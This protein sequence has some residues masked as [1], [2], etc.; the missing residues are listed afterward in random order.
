[1]TAESLRAEADALET[2][3][4]RLR[5]EAKARRNLAAQ[6]E[7]LEM[8]LP[9]GRQ[10]DTLDA[11]GTSANA[12]AESIP[13]RP[14]PK[15]RTKHPLPVRAKARGMSIENVAD[16]LAKK[17]RRKIPRTT[18]RSWYASKDSGD[19]RPIP[20]DAADYLALSPWDIPRSAWKN[21]IDET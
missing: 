16:E 8:G 12:A 1:M 17:L 15:F 18:V 14:G 5:A 10:S 7:Q 13:T 6:L 3:A 21:G 19:G 4:D 9:L 11:M 20:K 2:E